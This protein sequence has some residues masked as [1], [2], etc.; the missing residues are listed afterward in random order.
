M[1]QASEIKL[2]TLPEWIIIVAVLLGIAGY[3]AYPSVYQ[4]VQTVVSGDLQ[5]Q[6]DA[7]KNEMADVSSKWNTASDELANAKTELQI[8]KDNLSKTEQELTDLKGTSVPS[9]NAEELAET[10]TNLAKAQDEVKRLE[11][12]IKKK[13]DE[14][15]LDESPN[16]KLQENVW[17]W[18]DYAK[19]ASAYQDYLEG[20]PD[21]QKVDRPNFPYILL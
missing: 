8:F 11:Y 14:S 2:F 18:E 5:K 12:I 21:S 13:P 19:K 6:L 7:A 17:K 10:K 9:N 4:K 20:K 3:L 15:P 16:D 1:K